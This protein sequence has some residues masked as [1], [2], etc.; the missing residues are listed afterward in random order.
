[1]DERPEEPDQPKP[2][3]PWDGIFKKPTGDERPKTAK[4]SHKKMSEED[5][6]RA[7]EEAAARREEKRQQKIKIREEATAA[8]AEAAAAASEDAPKKQTVRPD[9]WRDEWLDSDAFPWAV[10]ADN[11]IY[12]KECKKAGMNNNLA[13]GSNSAV[14]ADNAPNCFCALWAAGKKTSDSWRKRD[15]VDHATGAASTGPC[16]HQTAVNNNNLV[17]SGAR[18]LRLSREK[19]LEAAKAAVL[20]IITAVYWLAL[21][22][23]ALAK[24]GSLCLLLSTLGV[25]ILVGGKLLYA[26]NHRAREMLMCLS[27]VTSASI[28]CV[29]TVLICDVGYQGQAMG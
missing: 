6:R 17:C 16:G 22:D 29:H 27:K 12:C 2:P 3:N 5:R 15:L 14:C 10:N 11:A 13:R 24:V 8:A 28:T 9:E 19:A 4:K 20:H 18:R 1:M 7:D 26:N 21:E 25:V 23:V